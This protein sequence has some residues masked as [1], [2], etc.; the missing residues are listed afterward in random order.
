[1]LL[2]P[3]YAHFYPTCLFLITYQLLTKVNINFVKRFQ[4]PILACIT[5]L[6]L[7]ECKAFWKLN[8]VFGHATLLFLIQNPLSCKKPGSEIQVSGKN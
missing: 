4:A 1:M 2:E 6:K 7:S 8:T 3:D 5:L